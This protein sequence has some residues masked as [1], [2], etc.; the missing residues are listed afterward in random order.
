MEEG[1]PAEWFV[2]LSE[3]DEKDLCCVV[4]DQIAAGAMSAS[5]GCCIL[6]E[7]CMNKVRKD[8]GICP[9]C[10][11]PIKEVV[12]SHKDR[13]KISRLMVFCVNKESGCEWKGRLEERL[14]KEFKTK[15]LCLFQELACQFCQ[16]LVKRKEMEEHTKTL[17]P[18]R[19]A[20]CGDCKGKLKWSKM[21]NHTETVC[22]KANLP[23]DNK[24]GESFFRDQLKEHLEKC[25]LQIVVCPYYKSGCN[26]VVLQKDVD[27]HLKDIS[28]HFHGL[29]E[30]FSELMKSH[31]E[32][33]KS[34][35][36]LKTEVIQLR[37]TLM[38]KKNRNK[39]C[40]HERDK[41]AKLLG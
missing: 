38:E 30:K 13:R 36:D 39:R 7:A 33:S 1:Y 34:H 21:K 24:C 37:A 8:K 11:Q 9:I 32:L 12:A 10:Q 17:C 15:H 14:D 35:A 41:N 18:E 20:L 22:P 31:Q 27:S 26:T 3:D 16:H 29:M 5:C 4:C 2:A 19:E 23:C 40:R 28:V 25:P 6:C